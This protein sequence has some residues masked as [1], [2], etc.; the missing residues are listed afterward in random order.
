MKTIKQLIKESNK[1][2]Y[3]LQVITGINIS[4]L[5][6]IQTGKQKPTEKQRKALKDY[7]KEDF[8]YVSDFESEHEARIA[9]EDRVAELEKINKDL[10]SMYSEAADKLR[11][12]EQIS[13]G[14]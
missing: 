4:T 8:V 13:K 9:A 3:E 14:Y 1:T 7:F 10:W 6:K 11:K 2:L 12:I 5:S